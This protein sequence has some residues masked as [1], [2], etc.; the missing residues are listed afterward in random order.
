M[1]KLYPQDN[2]FAVVG[3]LLVIGI[4]VIIGAGFFVLKHIENN[5]YTSANL[6]LANNKDWVTGNLKYEGASFK[7]PAKWKISADQS[8]GT[9]DKTDN[10]TLTGDHGFTVTIEN[11]TFGS[12]ESP[13]EVVG[14][15]P[16]TF[17][18]QKGYMDL[19]SEDTAA[20]SQPA[21]FD[22]TVGAVE[23]S[24]SSSN[25]YDFF[26]SKAASLSK[27][28]GALDIMANYTNNDGS[29]KTMSVSSAK[30]DPNYKDVLLLIESFKY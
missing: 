30:S 14:S 12:G 3:V 21:Q 23:L 24:R 19:L 16:L 26:P 29:Y 7:Y 27:Y 18:G 25:N 9:Y 15:V 8:D 4:L 11:G 2:G 17:I 20:A 5:S 6:N 1:R 10:I 13:P 28:Q 22:G